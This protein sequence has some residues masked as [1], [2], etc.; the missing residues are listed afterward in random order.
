M[1]VNRK[2]KASLLAVLMVLVL[3]GI[4][5]LAVKIASSL[6]DDTAKGVGTPQ[7]SVVA[8]VTA[9][10][11]PTVTVDETTEPATATPPT[12]SPTTFDPDSEGYVEGYG[13]DQVPGTEGYV[14][15]TFAHLVIRLPAD[16]ERVD[17]RA[18]AVA[19]TDEYAADGRPTILLVEV[20]TEPL[21]GVYPLIEELSN[22][23]VD[24]TSVPVRSVTAGNPTFTINAYSVGDV[25]DGRIADFLVY[26]VYDS[27]NDSV[28][29][30]VFWDRY[31]VDTTNESLVQ[32]IARIGE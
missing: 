18:T 19:N 28:N 21:T 22:G 13:V 29:A 23:C 7:P 11:A 1:K 10:P 30:V 24:P 14:D 32:L 6:D 20:L 31:S 15:Q 5:A 3:A 12:P 17:Q 9:S 27:V 8:T 16:Y 2:T 25:C 26:A 4:A